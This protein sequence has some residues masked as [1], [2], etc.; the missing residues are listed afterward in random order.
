[1][2]S[3]KIILGL[4]L[5]LLTSVVPAEAKDSS[6][7]PTSSSSPSSSPSASPSSSR[8]SSMTPITTRWISPS[9]AVSVRAGSEVNARLTYLYSGANSY[10]VT[11]LVGK[12]VLTVT[13][14]SYNDLP[15]IFPGQTAEQVI[16]SNPLAIPSGTKVTKIR[17]NTI[18]L[19]KTLNANI[20]DSV[21][22]SGTIPVDS[23]SFVKIFVVSC[24]T[25]TLAPMQISP[26]SGSFKDREDE[27]N[28]ESN[29]SGLAVKWKVAKNQQLGCY[30]LVARFSPNQTPMTSPIVLQPS[31][32]KNSATINVTAKNK[33]KD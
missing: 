10:S 28:L 7:E 27:R 29:K 20:A 21:K 2:K 23:L 16:S 15:I 3:Q 24:G 11:G 4:S 14:T 25:N 22:F 17:G 19:S 8:T 9:S 33:G 18:T 12:R 13:P 30:N 6:P 26:L 1:M 31:D 32:L 5:F